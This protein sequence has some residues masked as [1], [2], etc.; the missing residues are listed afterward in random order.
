MT[1]LQSELSSAQKLY[2]AGALDE[3]F[4]CCRNALKLEGGADNV[5]V[6]LTIAAILTAQDKPEQAEKAF[7][8]AL[9]IDANNVAA[10]KGLAVLLEAFGE[11]RREEL[12][13][14]YQKLVKLDGGTSAAK[15]ADT[16]SKP[17]KAVDWGK[18]LAAVERALGGLKIDCDDGVG[19]GGGGGGGGKSGG[20][21]KESKDP[22]AAE[23]AE[24]AARRAAKQEAAAK[25]TE[26]KAAATKAKAAARK[27][28]KGA[29]GVE[30][31]AT[32]DAEGDEGAE[33][34][35]GG[36]EPEDGGG[37]GDTIAQ[38][39]AELAALRRKV[40]AGEK[41]SGKMKRV[42]KKLEE[43]EARWKAYE[44]ASG[45]AGGDAEG[46]GGA[47]DMS[48][49]G[50]QFTAETRAGGDVAIASRASVIG[51]GIEVPNFSIRADSI[52][53][54]VDAKL[55]LRAGHRYGL[56]A[57]NGK[58]KT[59]LLKAIGS[60][61]L[62]GLPRSLD[63]LYVEQ[64]V[65][66]AAG[67]SVI[68]A[69]LRSDS[70]RSSLLA[71]ELRLESV[72][73]AALTAETRALESG[74]AA[75]AE[76][77]AG[78]SRTLT[79]QLVA[80]YDALEAHGSEACEARARSLLAGLGFDEAKQEAPT[81]TLSGG[82]RMRLALA[83]ALF[84]QP[85]LLLLD[86]P[87][88]HLDLDACIWL[89]EHLS[90]EK[91]STMLI[92]SHDQQHFLNHVCTD[93]ILIE[94]RKLH[95]FAGDYDDFTKRHDSFVAELRKKAMAEQK[96]LQK[97]QQAL[98]K[99]GAEAGSKSARKQMKER[100]EEIKAAPVERDYKVIFKIPTADRKLSPPLI[101]M[102][103]VGFSYPPRAGEAVGGTA[104][105][106]ALFS[107]VD[108]E[109]SMDS[110]VALVGP[111]GCGKST[112]LNL[113]MGNLAPSS[114]E[115]DQANGRLRVG[116]YAQH[117]VEALPGGLSPVEHL[118]SLL[119]LKPDRGSPTYQEVRHELG[120]KGLPS[121]AHELKIKDLS[122]GQK[123]RV[124]FA[125]LSSMRPHVLLMDEPTN[126]LDI[127]S[128]DALISAVNEF[129]G[130][131]VLISHDRRLLQRTNCA[132]WLCEGAGKGIRPLGSEFT[133]DKYE[134]KILKQ[135]EARQLAE[136]AKAR[137]R[138][139]QRRKKKE[140]AARQVNS[141]QASQAAS[142]KLK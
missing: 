9:S 102:R 54:L 62:T 77:A 75:A 43:A 116:G 67:E 83:R 19:G 84:L 16:S 136:E 49:L 100:V 53:L 126:H 140:A 109:L 123:A 61:A 27:T 65:R 42:L 99:G 7:S 38:Q 124:V 135:I 58:G 105:S 29:S 1:S 3:A 59:T 115:V 117:L 93:V 66:A 69:L 68:E 131:V 57:P 71:E 15:T 32:A 107:S 14:V 39:Q 45:A 128:I 50:A 85:E 127:E 125:S 56:V 108:F 4:A 141:N 11:E 130:G 23:K 111:N 72:I 17:T 22:T 122:G 87:T 6:H 21:K 88:N 79:E 80:V 31:A 82:W 114:G 25:A 89:Q 64:E 113:L 41:L 20:D 138:A 120:T 78:V 118:H 10:Y 5:N 73:E 40:A 28:T 30:T 112:F 51:D 129:E 33:G 133:F 76:A 92:V 2:K 52:E 18:K 55:S 91:K 46:G 139:E 110:R 70:K 86:E 103:G 121:F 98:S 35:T 134:S 12:L 96:E 48:A 13:P 26:E 74:D 142:K 36:D 90:H 97:L 8:K 63:V 94:Q 119:G 101:T 24:A 60:R 81:T 106:R 104:P 34:E 132:L 95:Y 44:A 137:A 47:T 37:G